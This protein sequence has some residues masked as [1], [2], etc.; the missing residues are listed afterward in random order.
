MSTSNELPPYLT[1]STYVVDANDELEM[2]RLLHQAYLLTQHMGGLFP[3]RPD[4]STM[5]D[6]LDIACGPGGWVIQVAQA[7]PAMQ[8]TG[9]DLSIRMVMYARA[10]ALVHGLPN[11]RF[12]LMDALKP[13]DFPDQSFDLVN[14]R[15]LFAFM[16]PAA[17]PNLLHECLRILRPGGVIRLTECELPVSNSPAVE[18][19]NALT[20]RAFQAAGKSFS[21]DGR[22][23]GIVPML[24][25]LLREAGFQH[26]QQMAQVLDVSAGPGNEEAHKGFY[27]DYMLSFQL[28]RA[29]LLQYG[30]AS[31]EEY[32]RLYQQAPVEMLSDDFCGIE[33]FLM[34]WGEKPEQVKR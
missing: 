3:E 28:G 8:V 9:I 11:A 16:P 5:H 29:F 21:P 31:E 26:I 25:R 15:L 2:A 32:D 17:W 18:R 14:G 13:L 6:V 20:T 30:G 19:L 12:R 7:Y 33:F 24:G 1:E 4:L 22:H 10:Q 23:V 34:V 27:Q